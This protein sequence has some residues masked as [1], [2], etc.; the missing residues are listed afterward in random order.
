MG[1]KMRKLIVSILLCL[2]QIDAFACDYAFVS[3]SNFLNVEGKI[4]GHFALAYNRIYGETFV[5]SKSGYYVFVEKEGMVDEFSF[6]YLPLSLDMAKVSYVP[7][8]PYFTPGP[9]TNKWL[10]CNSRL[11]LKHKDRVK[12]FCEKETNV[13]DSTRILI[14]K[15]FNEYGTTDVGALGWGLGGLHV[16][17]IDKQNNRSYLHV[18][19]PKSQETDC[20][21]DS[22]ILEYL[23]FY[24]F[25][26]DLTMNG[27]DGC[28]WTNFGNAADILK[29]CR[30]FVPGELRNNAEVR[31][32]ILQDSK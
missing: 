5:F 4:D 18:S 16:V 26:T 9:S 7:E 19:S 8:I 14:E 21:G 22:I 1:I 15:F 12:S 24:A 13:P 28:R 25:F 29:V 3:S 31:S 27:F 10:D 23:R 11:I 17:Q 30:D 6:A 2:L 32:Q 20:G